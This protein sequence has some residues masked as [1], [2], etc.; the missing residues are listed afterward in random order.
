MAQAEATV[1]AL[2]PWASHLYISASPSACVRPWSLKHWF[3]DKNKEENKKAI[4]PLSQ[5][6]ALKFL[7]QYWGPTGSLS[8]MPD[9]HWSLQGH[10]WE[11]WLFEHL[12]IVAEI[13]GS[14]VDS[15]TLMLAEEGL[16]MSRC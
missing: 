15:N 5:N 1:S 10:F 13:I 9:D 8:K 11:V 3:D 14:R 16:K 4:P 6:L 2:S 7:P 12:K